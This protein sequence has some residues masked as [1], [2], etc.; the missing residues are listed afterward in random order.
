M[1][2]RQKDDPGMNRLLEPRCRGGD[3]V[4]ARVEIANLVVPGLIGRYMNDDVGLGVAN[5]DGG[6][7]NTGARC[8]LHNA[9]QDAL[10]CLCQRRRAEPK[11]GDGCDGK[12]KPPR[13]GSLVPWGDPSYNPL[14]RYGL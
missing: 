10:A 2:V 6:T 9:R 13:V 5:G 12:R 11:E 7:R 8:I 14:R 3:V 1:I 4:G